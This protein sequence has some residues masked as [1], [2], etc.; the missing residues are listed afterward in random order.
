MTSHVLSNILS[1]SSHSCSVLLHVFDILPVDS[2]SV[3][4]V[5]GGAIE[6][7]GGERTRPDG[8]RHHATHATDLNDR[9]GQRR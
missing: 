9:V 1:T 3:L 6:G 2:C 5:G 4:A 8:E 7:R